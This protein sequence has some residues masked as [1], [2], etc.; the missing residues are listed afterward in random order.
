MLS[1]KTSSH[2]SFKHVTLLIDLF[3]IPDASL[4]SKLLRHIPSYFRGQLDLSPQEAND[5]I[6]KLVTRYLEKS[7]LANAVLLSLTSLVTSQA[8][9]LSAEQTS[10]TFLGP[11]A[12]QALQDS[13]LPPDIKQQ[14][15][16][17]FLF[18][19]PKTPY[20]SA[21]LAPL[22][23]DVSEDGKES[24]LVNPNRRLLFHALQGVLLDSTVPTIAAIVKQDVDVATTQ[25]RTSACMTLA[26]AVDALKMH[27]ESSHPFPQDLFDLPKLDAFLLGTMHH[28]SSPLF[29]PTITLFRSLLR[30]FPKATTRLAARLLDP[31]PGSQTPL[32]SPSCP[33]CSV[34]FATPPDFVTLLHASLSLPLL[35]VSLAALDTLTDLLQVLPWAL[36]L[37]RPN[38]KLAPTAF[39]RKVHGF[40]Q[41]MLHVAKCMAMQLAQSNKPCPSSFV[42]YFQSIFLSIPWS[43]TADELLLRDSKDLWGNLACLSLDT[44][45]SSNKTLTLITDML[46]VT[47]GGKVTPNG[48]LSCLTLPGR[49]WMSSDASRPFILKIL[50]SLALNGTSF[51]LFCALVRTRPQTAVDNWD[52]VARIVRDF[53]SGQDVSRRK[54]AIGMLES[55]MLGWRDFSLEVS[56]ESLKATHEPTKLAFDIL[57]NT[58]YDE[59]TAI[60]LQQLN[61]YVSL[62]QEDWAYARVTGIVS[63]HVSRWLALC[64]DRR[65]KVR[66][67]ACKATGEFCSRYLTSE[68]LLAATRN[69]VDVALIPHICS[70]MIQVISSDKNAPVRAMALFTLGNLAVSMNEFKVHD[71]VNDE[72][73]FQ[74]VDVILHS[75]DDDNDKVVA[76]AIRSSGHWGGI[77]AQK[78]GSVDGADDRVV[79]TIHLLSKRLVQTVALSSLEKR[80]GLTWKERSSA[81]KHGWG[82]CNAMGTILGFAQGRVLEVLSLR[83]ATFGSMV[84]LTECFKIHV[85]LTEKVVISVMAALRSLG[86]LILGRLVEKTGLIG[87]DIA[88]CACLLHSSLSHDTRSRENNTK[89][90]DEANKLFSYLLE[91]ATISDVVS[92]MKSEDFTKEVLEYVYTWMIGNQI[93]SRAF[94]LFALALQRQDLPLSEH[95]SMEQN[96]A[97]RAAMLHKQELSLVLETPTSAAT[98]DDE[99]DEL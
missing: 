17:L 30:S 19:L 73:S 93:E 64:S 87:E 25:L 10:R 80:A 95:V 48:T 77:M 5:C 99:P 40:L 76:N 33:C 20:S 74:I 14:L 58:L 78:E 66:S 94:E 82:C 15:C 49:K 36:W 88:I 63:N 27:H 90:V 52:N 86:P 91:T 57:H 83:D 67:A 97:S 24:T 4:Q 96:F 12:L 8:S 9:V 16:E 41:S 6:S 1:Q 62:S 38:A 22:V 26:K 56:D 7:N 54:F 11:I 69:D 29:L 72:Q 37:R 61:I 50:S 39:Y 32:T 45:A 59:Q 35:E 13:L 23:Q 34:P 21:L 42:A 71:I 89:L 60:L 92:A 65:G 55:I 98:L 79:R 47:T 31:Y 18:L 28:L 84:Q 43:Q 46:V 75:M 3:D 2:P 51:R 68:V 81:K 70:T 53:G 85:S 44:Q